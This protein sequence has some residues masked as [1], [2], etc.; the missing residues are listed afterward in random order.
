MFTCQLSRAVRNPRTVRSLPMCILLKDLRSICLWRARSR[1]SNRTIPIWI[2]S[3]RSQRQRKTGT[4]VNTE[5][6]WKT[7][8]TPEENNNSCP[9]FKKSVLWSGLSSTATTSVCIHLSNDGGSSSH[10]Q[11]RLTSR[12]GSWYPRSA[13]TGDDWRKVELTKTWTQGGESECVA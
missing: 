1:R 5:T 10:K 6:K 7:M 11:G 3:L 13:S 4:S 8:I 9:R 2:I 12:T